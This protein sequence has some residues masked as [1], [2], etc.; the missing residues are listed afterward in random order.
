VSEVAIS[1][2]QHNAAE[3][4]AE[5][6]QKRD[7]DWFEQSWLQDDSVNRCLRSTATLDGEL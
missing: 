3:E 6:N 1:F 7:I 4:D 5:E 2:P